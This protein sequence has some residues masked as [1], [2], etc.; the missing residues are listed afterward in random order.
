MGFTLDQ[1]QIRHTITPLGRPYFVCPDTQELREL[2][3]VIPSASRASGRAEILIQDV[4]FIKSELEK[5]IDY[6]TLIAPFIILV[7]TLAFGAT[8]ILSSEVREDPEQE[9]PLAAISCALDLEKAEFGS[10]LTGQLAQRKLD[11]SSQLAIQTDLGEIAIEVE[12][13]L[14]STQLIR[15][16][17]ACEDGR[18]TS[19]QFRTDSEQP[20]ELIE[21]G[22][23]LDP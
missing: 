20:G 22:E 17:V 21:L 6:R 3:V 19:L 5:K 18:A 15:G 4:G 14:G 1:H 8:Q 9:Q 10:W 12:Q 13:V 23:K 16:T 7:L 11:A 2:L